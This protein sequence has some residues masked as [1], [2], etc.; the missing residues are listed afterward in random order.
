VICS[1]SS[2]LFLQ[3]TNVH[4]VLFASLAAC[5]AIAS[6]FRVV[7]RASIRLA[8]LCSNTLMQRIPLPAARATVS[9][10]R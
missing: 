6:L 3:G 10:I 5:L 8:R 9:A 2:Y 4:V 7:E 1:F